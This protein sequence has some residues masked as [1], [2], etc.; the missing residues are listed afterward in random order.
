MCCEFFNPWRRYNAH[1][2]HL[3][4]NGK[5]MQTFTHR[6]YLL[7][8]VCVNKQLLLV[9][10][11]FGERRGAYKVLVGILEEGDHLEDPGVDGRLI[12]KQIFEKWDGARTESIWLRI[13]TGGGLL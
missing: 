6:T 2:Y 12:L 5:R 11:T 9:C 4:R 7:A 8:S 3:F 13:G 10:C 1:I